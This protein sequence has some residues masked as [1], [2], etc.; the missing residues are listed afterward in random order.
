M[1]TPPTRR[2]RDQTET[3]I[4]ERGLRAPRRRERELAPSASETS[5]TRS[6]ELGRKI[7]R[8]AGAVGAAWI[9]TRLGE[10]RLGTGEHR[11]RDE[12]RAERGDEHDLTAPESSWLT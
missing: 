5:T 3:L 2:R 8:D 9:A 4:G 7:A 11:P 1:T 12:R 10:R 6:G